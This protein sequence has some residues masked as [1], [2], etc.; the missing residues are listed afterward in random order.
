MLNI[1]ICEDDKGHRKEIKNVVS[2]ILFEQ[3][4]MAIESFSD[5]L[6]VIALI[7]NSMFF[8]DLVL[9]D[10]K[11]PGA[12]G[13]AVAKAIREHRL[14]TEIIFVTAHE[15]YV[16][17]GYVYKAFAFLKK[18][19]ST[20]KFSKE[21]GRYLAER[22]NEGADYLCFHA[23]GCRQRLNTRHIDYIES[24]KRKVSV[25]VGNT[26]LEFYAKL[27]DIERQCGSILVRTH[28]SF[29]VNA[30]KMKRLTKTELTLQN[31]QTVPVSKRH[32]DAACRAFERM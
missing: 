26:R 23:D 3:D 10:I 31:G 21:L 18:P 22:D 14:P 32:Y 29:L 24:S 4:D 20:T 9:L 15:E 30:G 7:D 27:D 8:F 5:G 16:F 2:N 12:D 25:V 19:V 17:E 1:A 28:Q 11:M 13:I 6:D